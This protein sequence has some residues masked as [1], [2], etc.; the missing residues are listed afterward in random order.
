VVRAIEANR[1]QRVAFDPQGYSTAGA[2]PAGCAP[3]G[4]RA[5]V[6]SPLRV[7]RPP[8]CRPIF[9]SMARTTLSRSFKL[10]GRSAMTHNEEVVRFGVGDVVLVDVTRP[11]TFFFGQCGGVVEYR[12]SCF[13]APVAG[14]ASRIRTA[15]WPL[16][17]QRNGCRAPSP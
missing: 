15:G 10:A 11:A 3:S 12:C 17:T 9:A 6:G 5:W 14:F 7:E 8:I 4:K 1:S 16:P 2:L 13:A